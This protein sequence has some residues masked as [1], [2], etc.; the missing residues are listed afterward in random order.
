LD[1][2]FE[3]LVTTLLTTR[4]HT[5]LGESA[6]LPLLKTIFWTHASYHDRPSRRAV[7]NCLV[8]LLSE[9]QEHDVLTPFVAALAQEA[10]KPGIA[11]SNAFNLVEWCSLLTQRLAGTPQWSRFG[12]Q[13]LQSQAAVLEKCLAQPDK[14]SLSHSATIV[15]RRGLRKLF[16]LG[17]QSKGA[18][19]EAVM[20]LSAKA[21]QPIMKN[22]PL[23]GIIAG[24]AMRIP[25][26]K[27][28]L[29]EFKGDYFAFYSREVLG[30]RTSV[31]AH[32]AGAFADFFSGFTT[33]ADFEKDLVPAL[34]KGLLRAPE[35]VL[36]DILAPLAY[37]V[38]KDD[39]YDLSP[40]V[41]K[42]LLKPIL[43][44]AKSTNATIRK[45][46]ADSLSALLTRAPSAA[47]QVV[48]EIVGL[49][50]GGK[51]VNADQ[52]LL[53]AQVLLQTTISPSKAEQTMAS[54]L[55]VVS[56]ETNDACLDVETTVLRTCFLA[57]QGKDPAKSVL[58]AFV[59]G[60]SEKKLPTRRIWILRAGEIL[61]SPMQDSQSLGVVTKFS[62]VALPKLVDTFNEVLSNP[63]V[64]AQNGLVVCGYIVAT[65]APFLQEHTKSSAIKT[66]LS[67]VSIEKQ[68]LSLEPKPSFLLNP[69]IYTKLATDDDLRWFA[70]ALQSVARRLASLSPAASRSW[71]DAFIY[72]LLSP[73]VS[74]KL[75]Q[76]VRP[77]LSAVYARHPTPVSKA[78]ADALWQWI[79]AV[80]SGDKESAAVISKCDEHSL[81]PVLKAICLSVDKMESLGQ[82]ASIGLPSDSA[83]LTADEDHVETHLCSLLVL[84]QGEV[85]TGSSWI[86]LCLKAGVDPGHLAEKHED[87]LLQVIM[88]ATSADQKVSRAE[89]IQKH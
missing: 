62:E 27:A 61:R 13:I 76:E 81:L 56:K 54:L 15:T 8:A 51:I 83:T 4:E 58:D 6:L 74:Y 70:C 11:A 2:E 7:Q 85:A 29:G 10:Q 24:V 84:G 52:R 82:A 9:S 39:S 80:E 66:A 88:A 47:D 77:A 18:I 5:E 79:V 1:D 60:L 33:V 65:V 87:H 43:A 25:G 63:L 78:M 17:P 36:C 59:K 19:K 16:S 37:S 22:A 71:A 21:S 26:A 68:C 31:P 44:N 32:I 69:R 45:G 55:S 35:I 28:A 72:L 86:E 30:S 89:R 57:C 38:P 23:L 64:A 34:E 46:A 12:S 48:D 42:S 40:V 14:H 67:K 53:H 49:L 20:M 41:A 75:A 73:T 3:K 50:K